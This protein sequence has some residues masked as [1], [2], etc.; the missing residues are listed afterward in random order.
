[1]LQPTA[2]KQSAPKIVVIEN[3]EPG[4]GNPSVAAP[5]LARHSIRS[6]G[7]LASSLYPSRSIFPSVDAAKNLPARS[8]RALG[9]MIVAGAVLAIGAGAAKVHQGPPVVTTVVSGNAALR[10]TPAGATEFWSKAPALVLDPSIE[11]MSPEAAAAIIEAFSTWDTGKLGIPKATFTISSTV[12]KAVQDGVSRI[13][14]APITTEGMEDA[15]ALTIGY[16]DPTTGALSETDVIFNSKYA[17]HA[18]PATATSAECNGDYDIQDVATHETGHVYGLGEDMEDT[19]TTMYVH[20]APCETH[21]R[22]LSTSDE[23]VMTALYKQAAA[24]SMS[25]AAQS[26]AAGCGATVASS[27][28]GSQSWAWGAGA[29]GALLVLRRRRRS[30]A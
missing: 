13:V 15:L 16:A 8:R 4:T 6:V 5:P 3:R 14:Y 28:P 21:K 26:Q 1:M 10:T 29:L 24:S 18:F 27:G 17:F 12:G 19:T 22:A 2:S 11:K 9:M 23:T 7:P 30:E 25:T 20:S